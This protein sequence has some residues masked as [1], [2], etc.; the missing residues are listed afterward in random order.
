[1]KGFAA[2]QRAH[3]AVEELDLGPD[4]MDCPNAPGCD[5]DCRCGG[6]GW[7]NAKEM[8]EYAEDLKWHD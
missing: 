8:E 4:S 2:A 5:E 6:K 1:M 3:D 7:L